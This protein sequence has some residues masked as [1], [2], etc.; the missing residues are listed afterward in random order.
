[1]MSL[2]LTWMAWAMIGL[3]IGGLSYSVLRLGSTDASGISSPPL[4]NFQIVIFMVIFGQSSSC[5]FLVYL[6]MRKYGHSLK[7]Q[8]RSTEIGLGGVS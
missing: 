5:A 6:E 1:M 7:P 4:N 2:P 3:S 8:R